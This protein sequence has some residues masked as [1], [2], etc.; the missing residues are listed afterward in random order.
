MS[1]SVDVLLRH[2]FEAELGCVPEVLIYRQFFDEQIVLR[3][4]AYQ[5]LGLWLSDVVAIDGNGAFL[6]RHT[7]VE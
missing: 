1:F 4:K 7:A 2:T 3:D 6:R 5:T